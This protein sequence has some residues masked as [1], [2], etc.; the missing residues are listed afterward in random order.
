MHAYKLEDYNVEEWLTE[1]WKSK[2]N[3]DFKRLVNQ[4]PVIQKLKALL[5]P[6]YE[7]ELAANQEISSEESK[8]D[9]ED[10]KQ[11]GESK[12]KGTSDEAKVQMLLEETEKLD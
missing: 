4:V 1:L 5:G 7:A 11:E 3:S 9:C 12:K 10:S 8:Q 6:Q 2:L